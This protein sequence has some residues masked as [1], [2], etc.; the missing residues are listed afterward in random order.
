VNTGAFVADGAQPAADICQCH[1]RKMTLSREMP[2]LFHF[3]KKESL[4]TDLP[5]HTYSF[6]DKYINNIKSI[7]RGG[8]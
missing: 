8:G 2:K 5:K 7:K 1:N 3:P 6:Q 4:I